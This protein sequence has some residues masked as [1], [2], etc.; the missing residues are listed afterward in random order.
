MSDATPR[1]KLNDE[2]GGTD[3]F[4]TEFD[5]L[6]DSISEE[7]IKSVAM[8]KNTDPAEL[9]LLADFIDPEALDALFK[10]QVDGTPRE[11]DGR[12]EFDFEGYHVTVDNAGSINLRRVGANG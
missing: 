1:E 2:Q 12:V 9:A 10:P 4:Y 3:T 8:L 11:T 5:P 7:L 6:T